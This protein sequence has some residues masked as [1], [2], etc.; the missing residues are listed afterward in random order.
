VNLF[1]KVK[2]EKPESQNQKIFEKINQ[3]PIIHNST[4]NKFDDFIF[5]FYLFLEILFLQKFGHMSKNHHKNKHPKNHFDFSRP[6][7]E[8]EVSQ[9]LEENIG[10][11][12]IETHLKQTLPN[13][14]LDNENE[15]KFDKNLTE[16]KLEK[17]QKYLELEAGQ[18]TEQNLEQKVNLLPLKS[19]E[20]TM[21]PDERGLLLTSIVHNKQDIVDQHLAVKSWKEESTL[22]F[23]EETD[24]EILKNKREFDEK[25]ENLN[26]ENL[27]KLGESNKSYQK[28]EAHVDPESIETMRESTETLAKNLPRNSKNPKNQQ[29]T[30]KFDEHT[31]DNFEDN[32]EDRFESMDIDLNAALDDELKP[33]KKTPKN[34]TRGQGFDVDG[35]SWARQKA[36]N[37]FEREEADE[38]WNENLEARKV[39]IKS[40]KQRKIELAQQ[41]YQQQLKKSNW[42]FIL[43]IISLACVLGAVLFYFQGLQ[44]L[45]LSQIT[46]Q[47]QKQIQE[48]S[49]NYQTKVGDYFGLVQEMTSKI[50]PDL[51]ADCN[52]KEYQEIQTDAK[53]IEDLVN[54]QLQPEKKLTKTEKYWIFRN[55]SMDAEYEKTVIRYQ[56][57]LDTYRGKSDYLVDFLYFLQQRNIW[58]T[59]CQ[60]LKETN[61]LVRFGEICQEFTSKN[62]E[63]KKKRKTKFWDNLDSLLGSINSLCDEVENSESPTK[64]RQDW[65]DKYVFLTK[66]TPQNDNDKLYQMNE[67]ALIEFQTRSRNIYQIYEQKTNGIGYFYLLNWEN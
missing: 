21:N 42:N 62:N 19:F 14:N 27:G 25:I 26:F 22:N 44:P 1:Q 41:S 50:K 12:K 7:S 66:Y 58:L 3:K 9:K 37:D 38:E 65:L 17:N 11:P 43:K 52:Q 33:T 20:T 60:N 45:I 15:Q 2:Y 54:L 49:L 46:T 63:Y 28:F 61:S 29:N 16:K 53:K 23:N 64:W 39:E 48:L 18:N 35:L 36:K 40:E 55:S 8:D 34:Q 30:Q 47:N 5:I 4:K 56:Q 13:E 31:E 32:F 6:I 51:N 67:Q 24:E 59:T 10:I 57:S